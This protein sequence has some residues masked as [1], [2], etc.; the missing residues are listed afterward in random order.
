MNIV[1][2]KIGSFGHLVLTAI[3]VW[4]LMGRATYLIS[5]IVG[6]IGNILATRFLANTLKEARPDQVQDPQDSQYLQDRYGM[7]SLPISC[8]LYATAFMFMVRE[9]VDRFSV[10]ALFIIGIMVYK[11]L[12]C[13]F[14]SVAQMSA[15]GV[16]GIAA[17]YVVYNVAEAWVFVNNARVGEVIIQ[18]KKH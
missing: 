14:Y 6:C 3:M 4:V 11:N 9:K 5:F 15:G 1:V 10:V 7:P 18:P 2:D 13:R 12:K 16:M 17:A 8:A